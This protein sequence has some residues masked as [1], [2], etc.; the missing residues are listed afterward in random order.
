MF[1]IP[2]DKYRNLVLVS[3]TDGVGTKVKIATLTGIHDTIGIDLVAMCVNDVVVH[4]AE[5][6]FFL[7]YYAT[8][9]LDKTAAVEVIRGIVAGC[10][11][12]GC[13]LIG[14]ETAE[15]PGVYS[16]GIYD[17]A[18]FVVGAVE[19][20]RLIDGS[21]IGIGNVIL[22]IASTGIHSNG[23]SL[24]RKIV[25]ED[26]PVPLDSCPEE[27]GGE[28]LQDALLRPTRIY[29][30]PVLNLCRDFN[31]LGLAH[32]TGGG[33]I[34]NIP[35]IL[36]GK[37]Q[38]VIHSRSW[39]RPPIFPYLQK[40]GQVSEEDMY[41]VFNNGIGMVAVVP[42]QEADEALARLSSLGERAWRIGEIGRRETGAPAVRL[43]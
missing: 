4:G 35:R 31:V 6:L 30:K 5:P 17:L 36:P 42:A 7:D 9:K 40:L 24:V 23:Y 8:G 2:A 34:E 33:L 15:M 12:A 29:V 22:G 25:L 1:S 38:A 3:S 19:R 18:G 27:L 16:N 11:Q 43:V 14:G 37:C 39:P 10:K 21:S 20:D 13:A 41:R 32:I 28:S 26:H